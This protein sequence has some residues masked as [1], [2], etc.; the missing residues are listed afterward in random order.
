VTERRRGVPAAREV[1]LVANVL[2]LILVSIFAIELFSFAATEANLLLFND[3]PDVYRRHYDGEDWRTQK[4]AWGSW[5]R[6]NSSDRHRS[7]CFDVRYQANEIGARDGP[8]SSEKS[9]SAPRYI[10]LGDSFAE[11]FGIDIQQTAQAELERLTGAEVYNFGSDGYF[12]PVQYYLVYKNLARQYQ[13]DAVILFFLPANDFTDNDF[14]VW[15]SLFPTWYRPYY[16]KEQGGR[17]SIFYPDGAVPDDRYG[18]RPGLFKRLLID[19][20]FT[21][22]TVRTI[23]YLVSPS[24]QARWNYSGYFDASERQQEAALYFLEGIVDEAAQRPVTILVISNREDL[25]RIQSG[26][27]YKNQYWYKRLRTL[28]AKRPNVNVIDMAESIPR[29]Y[30]RFF[31]PCDNHWNALGNAE[32]ARLVA[33]RLLQEP[34]RPSR[35]SVV[36][37]EFTPT[38]LVDRAD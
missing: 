10:L 11:G 25:K 8:F 33:T 34:A 14:A 17:Y 12:G 26:G 2:L 7:N 23:K 31:H 13:H 4:E 36:V 30:E 15:K 28:Q 22:N 16:K 29:D 32:A 5:H 27:D 1:E 9:G 19:Y 38:A 24:E 35:E 37:E 18:D 21:A 3:V 6:P 20:T